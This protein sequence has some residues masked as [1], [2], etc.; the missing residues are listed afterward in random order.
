MLTVAFVS[1]KSGLFTNF[2]ILFSS[3]TNSQSVRCKSRSASKVVN[4]PAEQQS[5]PVRRYRLRV[6]LSAVQCQ[7]VHWCRRDGASSDAN[8]LIPIVT[9]RS[10]PPPPLSQG[11][12]RA[13][14]SAGFVAQYAR[15]RWLDSAL[16]SLYSTRKEFDRNHTFPCSYHDFDWNRLRPKYSIFDYVWPNTT[17][18]NAPVPELVA[19]WLVKSA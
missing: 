13:P 15:V 18:R 8:Y 6:C 1:C 5:N 9:V 14:L 12:P 7:C 4:S 19:M 2:G 17:V 11:C 10:T 16:R 3:V